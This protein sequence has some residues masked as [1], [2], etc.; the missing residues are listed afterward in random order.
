MRKP[1][2]PG[3]RLQGEF[4]L[5]TGASRGFGREIALALAE[6]GANVAV[7]YNKSKEAAEEVVNLIKKKGVDSFAVQADIRKFDDVKRMADEVWLRWGRC[8][9]LVNN[10]GET[11]STQMSWR[12][13]SEEVIDETLALDVKG[14]LFCLHEFGRRML[15]EQKSGTIVNVASNVIVTGS[16]RSPIYAAAKYGVIGLTKS[17]ALALAPYVRVN[18]VAPGYMD[19]PSLRARKDWTEERRKWIV[20]HTP[21]RSIGKPE[22]IARIVVFLASQDSFHMTGNTIICDGGFSMPAA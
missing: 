14:T 20:Q 17:Y 13:L 9:I 2:P 21:L 22:N 18:A 11:A 16:P 12:E 7:N 15:D 3:K 8:D 1:T 6:E 19:T 5:V 4:A 10:A